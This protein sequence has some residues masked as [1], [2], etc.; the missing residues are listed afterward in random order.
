MP[1][2]PRRGRLSDPDMT[3]SEL[4]LGC[5]TTAAATGNCL[6]RTLTSASVG[7]GSLS[8]SGQISAVAQAAVAANLN[9]PFDA[10]LNFSA[11]IAFNF[12]VFR[13]IFTQ[14][15]EISFCDVFNTNIR[16]D[17]GICQD[18]FRAGGANT[19]DICQTGFDTFV[20]WEVNTFNSCHVLLPLPLLMLW[21]FA[22]DEQNAFA[23]NNFAFCASFTD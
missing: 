14:K 5:T 11:Q 22:N 19:I 8:A 20:T 15:S 7:A 2:Q 4:L 10:H 3:L 6:L 1:G 21:V 12:E 13:D 9:Q 23:S 17:F 18:P 16:I